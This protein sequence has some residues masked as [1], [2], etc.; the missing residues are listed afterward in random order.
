MQVLIGTYGAGIWRLDTEKA[1]VA[2]IAEAQDPSWLLRVG[3]DRLYAAEECLGEKQG[4]V[5]LGFAAVQSPAAE[6]IHVIWPVQRMEN[7]W[8]RPITP[9]EAWPCF[10]WMK[11][12][13]LTNLRFFRDIMAG[14]TQNVRRART[15]I[16]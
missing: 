13:A 6:K 15:R 3:A 1:C 16:L 14:R 5:A 8:R 4:R 9:A 7:G 2:Q 12:A 11:L 10:R